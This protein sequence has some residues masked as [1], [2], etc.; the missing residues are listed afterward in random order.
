MSGTNSRESTTGRAG[1]CTTHHNRILPVA[2][3][4]KEFEGGKMA[5]EGSEL[6]YEHLG[7]RRFYIYF[8]ILF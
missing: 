4:N 1:F 5:R 7:I 3:E 2:M 6:E 8:F